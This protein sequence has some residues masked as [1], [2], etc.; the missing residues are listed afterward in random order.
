MNITNDIKVRVDVP[1]QYIYSDGESRK[2]YRNSTLGISVDTV[3]QL[4][5]LKL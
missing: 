2:D 1:S 3:S 5:Y 4:S